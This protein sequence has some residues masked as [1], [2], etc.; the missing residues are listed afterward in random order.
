MALPPADHQ[1]LSAG[2]SA[3]FATTHWSVVLAAGERDSPQARE[4]M[5][6]LCSAYWYPLYAFVRRQGHSA[7]QAQDLTQE[8]FTRLLEKDYLRAVDRGRGR[9]RTFLLACFRHFLA[10]EYDRASAKKRGGGRSFLSIDVRATEHRNSLEPCHALTAEKLFERRWALT[11]LEQ[12]LGR[13]RAEFI[14][15]GRG[16]LFDQL[17]GCLT[18]DQPPGGY[19]ELAH[20]LGMTAGAVTVAVHRLRQRYREILRE[21]I[22]QTV[23]DQSEIDGEIRDLFAALR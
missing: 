16:P 3:R 15:T 18:G 9:F 11:L 22:A 13:L 1:S 7:D 12:T 6:R 5:A 17:K 2:D 20:R 10:N 19:Q 8:F 4:A 23:V 14:Q 21:E